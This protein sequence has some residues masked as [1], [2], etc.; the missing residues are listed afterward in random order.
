MPLMLALLLAA[1]TTPVAPIVKGTGLPPPG[2]EESQVMIPVDAIFAAIA[3]RDS[4][5]FLAQVRPD[6]GA[7]VAT[8]NPD[9]TRSVTHR[10]W[11]E[12]AARFAPG[13]ERFEERLIDPAVEVDGDIAM[14]WGRYNFLIDGKLHHCGYDHFDLVREG[15]RW[16]VQNLSW[17]SRTLGCGA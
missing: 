2:T 6:G 17:S 8:E 4:T 14:V 10:S 11:S 5:A 1:Q 13:P 7:T 9:G 3:A 15:G 16:K 12:V